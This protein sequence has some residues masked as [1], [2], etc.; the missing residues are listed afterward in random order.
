MGLKNLARADALKLQKKQVTG[1]IGTGAHAKVTPPPMRTV[2]IKIEGTVP[3][4]MNAFSAKA[5]EM[6]RCKQSSG[7]QAK[8]KRGNREAKDFQACYEAAK[9]ISTE[10]WL[11]I[12]VMAFKGALIDACRTTEIKMTHAK[13]GIFIVGDG[14]DKN[15]SVGLTKITKGEPFYFE[16]PVRIPS[17]GAI[18]L[19][20]RPMWNPGWQAVVTIR[21]NLELFSVEDIT[22]LLWRA[23]EF[24]GILEGRA[25]SKESNGQNWGHFTL[26]NE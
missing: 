10:G 26:I 24:C 17:S 8:S 18:D 12:P 19:R 5:H 15:Y 23:G 3:L 7:T 6:I 1:N 21:F 4:V 13:I 25:S 2:R 9:H 20:A 22:N 14:Y 16:A 11:G